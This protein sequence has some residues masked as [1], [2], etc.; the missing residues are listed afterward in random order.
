MEHAFNDQKSQTALGLSLRSWWFVWQ[1]G[2]NA[3]KTRTKFFVISG[4]DPGIFD[5]CGEGGG[6]GGGVQTLVQKGLLN[7]FVVNNSLAHN[8]HTPSHQSRLHVIIPWPLTA[9]H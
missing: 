9:L 7:S 8:P 4:A 5:G 6:G 1:E 3:G 2:K